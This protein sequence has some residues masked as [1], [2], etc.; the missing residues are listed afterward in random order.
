MNAAHR[1]LLTA[2]L[3]TL[4][5]A[6]AIA[7]AAD[8]PP[9]QAASSDD[10]NRAMAGPVRNF[11]YGPRG[12]EGIILSTNGTFVQ[13]NMPPELAAQIAQHVAVGD[14]IEVTG[15][16]DNGPPPPPPGGPDGMAP[17]GGPPNEPGPDGGQSPQADHPVYRLLTLT[18]AKGKR[19]TA[20]NPSAR[21]QVHVEGT[22]KFLN[23]DRRGMVNGAHL[24]N[25]DVIRVGPREA[26]ELELAPNKK[27]SVDGMAQPLQG[28]GRLI[29]AQLINGT[30]VRPPAGPRGGGTGGDG[31]PPR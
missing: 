5:A 15:R 16:I 27:L 12:I 31:P 19:Y 4:A 1:L 22:V 6:P 18:D 28:G 11:N 20:E 26:E 23:Y 3:A 29:E 25:G 24:E 14:Q 2:V 7:S 10:Q 21:R 17:P 8:D 30:S 9:S 13:L